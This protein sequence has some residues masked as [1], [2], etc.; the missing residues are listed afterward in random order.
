MLTGE[1]T[2][3]K[4]STLCDCGEVLPLQMMQSNAGYY[5]GYFCT[6]CGPYGRETA[7]YKDERELQKAFC[8]NTTGWRK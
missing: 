5:L 3:G 6:K 4:Q 8:N 7:Y 2:G 1:C